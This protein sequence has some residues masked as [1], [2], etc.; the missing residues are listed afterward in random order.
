MLAS[1]EADSLG[2][3]PLIT[4]RAIPCKNL[5]SLHAHTRD[6]QC[7]DRQQWSALDDSPL[8]IQ[9]TDS[10][11]CSRKSLASATV[12]ARSV[13]AKGMFPGGQYANTC[14]VRWAGHCKSMILRV[15]SLVIE[16]L[17]VQA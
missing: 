17:L 8:Q 16:V 1:N 2:L 13:A 11:F 6:N 7:H 12:V 9:W 15:K 4:N 14:M 10:R 3:S 5:L